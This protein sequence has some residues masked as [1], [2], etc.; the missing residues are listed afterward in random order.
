MAVLI[1]AED[2]DA[3]ADEMVRA[4]ADR[5]TLVHRVNTAWFP[6]ELTVSFDLDGGRW[7]GHMITP[8]HTIELADIS[9]VG[10]RAPRAYRF[11]RGM[12]PAERAHA[13]SEAK[14]GLGGVLISMPALWVNHPTRLARAAYKPYQ[15]VTA[16]RCGLTVPETLITN[17]R[18]SVESFAAKGRTVAKVLGSNTIVEQGVRKLTFTRLI[19]NEDLEDLRGI[20]QTTHLFQRW[21]PKAYDVR[22]IVIGEH[23]T[24]VAIRAGSAGGYIDWRADYDHL[25]YELIEMPVDVADGVRRLMESMGIVYGALD[26][27]VRPDRTWTFLEINAGGQYGWLEDETGAP[28]TGQLADLLAAGQP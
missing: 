10:Y 12:N 3:T 4:L 16:A 14:F 25:S 20:E 26:F 13:N 18:A 23:M 9:A 1:L 5:G 27:V 22:V 17:E 7:S 24:A 28:L 21:V 15:L 2:I 19:H 6:I 11:P 8:R